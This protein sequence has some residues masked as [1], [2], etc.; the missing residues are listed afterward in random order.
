MNLTTAI[1][2]NDVI[3]SISIRTTEAERALFPK[4]YRV[5]Q[6]YVGIMLLSNDAN[7]GRNEAGIKRLVNMIKKVRAAG[8]EVTADYPNCVNAAT[9]E[10]IETWLAR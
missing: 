8:G 3:F 1:H 7:G 5:T 9:L 10:Q 2:E 4:S 6:Q